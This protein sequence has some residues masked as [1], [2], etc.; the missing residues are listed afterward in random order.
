MTWMSVYH[1]ECLRYLESRLLLLMGCLPFLQM[2]TPFYLAR[3]QFCKLFGDKYYNGK[4]TKF[5]EETGWFRV[6]YKDRDE[7]D[8]D[9]HELEEVLQPLDINIPLEEVVTKI[10]KKKH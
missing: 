5:D 2:M 3:R 8:L 10:I 4:V 7:E 9:W 1:L 6:K